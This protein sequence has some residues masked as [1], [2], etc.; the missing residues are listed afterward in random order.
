MPMNFRRC[1]FLKGGCRLCPIY[2][3]RHCFIEPSGSEM[4]V[5]MVRERNESEWKLAFNDFFDREN[6]EL[7]KRIKE[8][9]PG[10]DE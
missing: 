8:F 3:G 10:C 1:P 5:S 7:R 2:R 9:G 4:P 6:E